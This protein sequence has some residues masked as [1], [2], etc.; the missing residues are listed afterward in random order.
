[1]TGVLDRSREEPYRIGRDNHPLR[2]FVVY[3]FGQPI[4][5]FAKQIEA[6]VEINRQQNA[7]YVMANPR[8]RRA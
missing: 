4:E 5:R 3:R 2:P 6:V 8:R 7:D 1:M